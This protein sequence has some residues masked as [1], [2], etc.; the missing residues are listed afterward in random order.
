MCSAPKENDSKVNDCVDSEDAKCTN[1]CVRLASFIGRSIRGAEGS[2]AYKKAHD[3][4][5]CA[6]Q[7][8]QRVKA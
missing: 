1:K 2:R 6:L 8:M 3:K 4:P 5:S 7:R